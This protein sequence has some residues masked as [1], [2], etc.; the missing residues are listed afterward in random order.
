MADEDIHKKWRTYLLGNPFTIYTDQRSLRELM[1][2]VIQIPEQQFYLAKLLGYS[3][4][5]AYKPGP[6]NRVADALSRVHCFAIT[7]P[8]LVIMNTFKEQLL[9]DP[10][11][12]Q[13]LEKIMAT[14]D[15]Y[16]EFEILNGLIFFKGKLFIPSASPL[17]QTLLEEFH[18]SIIG[19]HSGIHR[20]Y[21]RLH[22]NVFWHGMR[23]D[24]AQF[25]K[26]CITCQQI[27]PTNHL[28][29]GLLQPLPIPERVWEDI[30]LDFIVGLPSFQ[31][32][33]VILVVV[34]R[35]SKAAHFGALPTHF[36]AAKVADLFVK[37]I[38]KLHGMPRS[39]VSDRDP[40]FL[41]QFW[42]ELFA[43]SGT[44]L[45][46]S[47][48][49]HPQSDGQ[50]E[51]VNKVLQQYLRCFVQDKPKQWGQFLHWA[52]WH[53]NTAIHTSTGLLPYQVV[54]GR[55]P[56]AL[57]DYIPGSSKLQAVDAMLSD[58]DSVLEFLK[59]KLS[60][61]QIVM[62][63]FTDQKRIPHKFKEG[64]LVFV[65]LR[66]YRQNSVVG[67]RIH[68]LSK[69]YYGPFKIIQA[70]GVVAFKLELPSTSK[71]HPVFH[72]SQLKPC[73]GDAEMSLDLPP[74]AMDNKPCIEPMVI[75]DWKN[76][77]GD[78]PLEVLVQ[79]AGLPPEE[80]SWE[81]YQDLQSTFPAFNHEDM[82]DFEE[83]ADVMNPI[84]GGADWDHAEEEGES[85]PP[86]RA[87]RNCVRPKY[88]N[89]F[90]TTTTRR[91]K[92]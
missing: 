49:Y 19:G 24:V 85:T 46:M 69:R 37:T 38:S 4:E 27:K 53:Y 65:K 43:L 22:E 88:L 64:D 48:T 87:K 16:K 77:D 41:S 92:K 15:E 86:I 84:V 12:Q 57:M 51:I 29:Y 32:H 81:D 21:G 67:R 2:Q 25:V 61:A 89:D 42:K 14:P 28:P 35:L 90:V 39:I 73:F 20:T 47:T 8:H 17:K 45:R 44:K 66:P 36:T 91:C 13:L 71:I 23:G 68:K 58:R 63:E 55:A 82:V 83:Q 50:T 62:K 59:K 3:Y 74:D 6:Q 70:V 33:T 40:V 1:T 52:E 5:I 79:W 75:L 72:T 60:K 31:N 78:E 7:V 80:A 9:D 54:Y 10:E 30:S 76:G 34:D 56:P 11:F 18:S 26:S